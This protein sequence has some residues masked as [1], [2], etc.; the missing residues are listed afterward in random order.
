M[1]YEIAKV[2]FRQLFPKGVLPIPIAVIAAV[3]IGWLWWITKKDDSF[4]VKKVAFFL[5]DKPEWMVWL[6]A[7]LYVIILALYWILMEICPEIKLGFLLNT[8][9]FVLIC[10]PFLVAMCFMVV[11]QKIINGKNIEDKE[12]ELDS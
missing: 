10:I 4:M 9:V 11:A 5:K 7:Y 3:L 2:M 1:P 8:V 6:S 12:N